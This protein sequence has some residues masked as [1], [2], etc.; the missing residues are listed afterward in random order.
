M[1]KDTSRVII[2]HERTGIHPCS[3]LR[4]E[5]ESE[6]QP[7]WGWDPLGP[8]SVILQDITDALLRGVAQFG[9][10]L[11]LGRGGVG[12]NPITPIQFNLIDM[13]LIEG[14]VKTVYS[15]ESADQVLIEYHDKVTAGNGEKK[16]IL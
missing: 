2:K 7:A 8:V 16:T 15:T 1:T 12:S 5:K 14:K 6:I 4:E 11:A 13:K 10:A 3:R 9:R